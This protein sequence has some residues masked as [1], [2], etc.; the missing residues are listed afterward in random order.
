LDRP[1]TVFEESI[2]Q[3]KG[4]SIMTIAVDKSGLASRLVQAFDEVCAKP[5]MVKRGKLLDVVFLM[6]VGST[7][8][9]VS[10][11]RGMVREVRTGPFVTQSYAFS[12]RASEATWHELWSPRPSP[13]RHD[14]IALLKFRLLT[15]EGNLHPFMAN[16]FFFKELLKSPRDCGETKHG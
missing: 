14:V 7:E 1:S 9:L 4:V 2:V 11:D 3:G 8:Y 12:V 10:I 5:F 15:L 13:G 6:A 16:L